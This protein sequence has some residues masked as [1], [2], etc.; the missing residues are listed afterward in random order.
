M[1]TEQF[2]RTERIL[3]SQAMDQIHKAK[4]LVFGVGGVGGYTVEALARS[5]VGQLDLVDNDDIVISNL[6]RQIIALHSTIGK[7]KVDAF[8]E[9]IHDISPETIVNVYPCFYLPET[10]DQFDFT[11]YDYI[12][13]AIDTVTAKIDIICKAEREGVPVISAMGCGNRLDPTRLVTTDIYNTKGDPLAKV[14]RYEL[15]RRGIKKLPVVYSTEPPLKIVV[16]NEPQNGKRRS[17][18]GSTA[19]VPSAAGI[20]LASKIITD[21]IH[22]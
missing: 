5:G 12:V 11:K 21:I 9:R 13:D 18:P 3:G 8:K 17:I 1:N 14:M 19:F 2:S 20:F 4:I 7:L 22:K 6:N 16:D 10:G 15:K